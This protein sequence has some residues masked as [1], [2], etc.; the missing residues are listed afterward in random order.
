M[1]LSSLTYSGAFLGSALAQPLSGYLCRHY[2]WRSVFYVFGLTTIGWFGLWCVFAASTP[3][4]CYFMRREEVEFIEEAL[5][6]ERKCVVSGDG[7]VVGSVVTGATEASSRQRPGA[8]LQGVVM[9]WLRGTPWQA[10]L[11]STAVWAMCV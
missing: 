2:G 4:K 10:L 9:T 8:T 3:A 11:S 7:S 6:K 1:Q 5:A